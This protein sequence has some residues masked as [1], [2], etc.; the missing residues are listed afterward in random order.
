M[1]VH[2]HLW[3]QVT[4]DFFT[5]AGTEKRNLGL[6]DLKFCFFGRHLTMMKKRDVRSHSLADNILFFHFHSLYKIMER[7][8]FLVPTEIT[9]STIAVFLFLK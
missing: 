3:A 4:W 6:V 7:S 1:Q 5:R 9:C 8:L 2:T